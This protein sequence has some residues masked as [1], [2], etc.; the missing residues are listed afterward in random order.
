MQAVYCPGH[1]HWAHLEASALDSFCCLP[2]MEEK[3]REI[4]LAATSEIKC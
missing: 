3:I 4:P 1:V 2:R